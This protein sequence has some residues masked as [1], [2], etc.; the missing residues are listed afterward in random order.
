[1][2]AISQEK[3]LDS[4]I[5]LL[6]EGYK[7]IS[8][9]CENLQSDIFETRMALQ[10]VICM[11]NL[12][13]VMKGEFDTYL[14]KWEKAKDMVLFWIYMVPITILIVGKN[15]I[16]SNRNVSEVG[17]GVLLIFVITEAKRLN[18]EPK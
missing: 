13:E 15:L 7:F 4:T 6:S 12:M 5:G 8:N 10:K 1:M 17:M 11:Q 9:R 14:D 16:G 3:K 2:S 18:P